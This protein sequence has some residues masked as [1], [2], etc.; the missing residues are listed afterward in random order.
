MTPKLRFGSS[1]AEQL[2]RFAPCTVLL[3][4]KLQHDENGRYVCFSESVDAEDWAVDHGCDA[5]TCEVVEWKNGGY[6]HRAC[7]VFR[8]AWNGKTGDWAYSAIKYVR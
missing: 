5:I 8:G 7:P 4:E 2:L 3:S 6:Y 1:K